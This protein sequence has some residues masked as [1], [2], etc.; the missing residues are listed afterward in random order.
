[1]ASIPAILASIHGLITHLETRLNRLCLQ[2]VIFEQQNQYHRHLAELNYDPGSP[3]FD[4]LAAMEQNQEVLTRELRLLARDLDGL[5]AWYQE[6]TAMEAL[7]EAE[8]LDF[9]LRLAGV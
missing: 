3:E 7:R 2:A 5:R 1:M 9:F 8:L 4:R 6:Y